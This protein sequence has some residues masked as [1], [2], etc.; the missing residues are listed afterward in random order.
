MAGMF[1]VQSCAEERVLK[2]VVLHK[3]A[4]LT[5]SENSKVPCQQKIWKRL[6]AKSGENANF[7]NAHFNIWKHFSSLITHKKYIT[8]LICGHK[9]N[10][11][12][13]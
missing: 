3:W 10:T 12:L 6:G 13:K 9:T 2:N 1:R 4:A 7:A 5:H 8:L 11:S